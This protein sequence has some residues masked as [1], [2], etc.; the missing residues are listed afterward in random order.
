MTTQAALI[1]DTI[2]GMKRTISSYNYSS[3]SGD[4]IDRCTNRGNKLKR[5]ARYVREGQ[6]DRPN[7]PRVYKKKIEHGGYHRNIIS[8]NPKRY[9]VN[10][11]RLED[12]EEDEEADAAAAEVNPYSGVVLH[13]SISTSK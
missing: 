12:D 13:G 4:S 2:A 10:G 5:K 11:D 7:G 6:L 1:A 8:Q 9:D 3:E